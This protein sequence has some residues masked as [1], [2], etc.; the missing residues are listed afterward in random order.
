MFWNIVILV[1]AVLLAVN[2]CKKRYTL[3]TAVPKD[4]EDDEIWNE[5][6]KE[7]ESIEKKEKSEENLN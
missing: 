2:I 4:P 3:F 1:V 7:E 5:I 6:R